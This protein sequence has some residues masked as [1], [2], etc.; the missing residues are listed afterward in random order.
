[1]ESLNIDILIVLISDYLG[2]NCFDFL[3]TMKT[4]KK[5]EY[6]H[7][8][9]NYLAE[10]IPLNVRYIYNCN[11]VCELYKYKNLLR[12]E[13]GGDFNQPIKEKDLPPNLTHLTF[14]YDFNQQLGKNVLPLNLTHLTFSKNY[15]HISNTRN[16][17]KNTKI[18]LIII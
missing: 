2:K 7:C 13:F 15:K 4:V 18:T 5:Y 9:Y 17:I 1:M 10:N 14:G 3:V 12:L 6:L 8:E 16:L 11:N